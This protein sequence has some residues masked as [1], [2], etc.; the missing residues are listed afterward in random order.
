MLQFGLDCG[1]GERNSMGFG[2]MNIRR[3]PDVSAFINKEH[4]RRLPYQISGRELSVKVIG[5]KSNYTRIERQV[6]FL[7]TP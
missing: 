3:H 2:F 1:L 6:R 5:F 7:T 4:D